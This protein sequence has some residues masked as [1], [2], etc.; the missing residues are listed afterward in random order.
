M[1]QAEK[2]QER[3]NRILS[4][5]NGTWGVVVRESG[6]GV[7]FEHLAD[8]PFIAESVIKV[9]IMAAV[10][11]ACAQG[12][13]SLE[14]RIALRRED[15]VGGSG[16]LSALS[17]GLRL[18]VRELVT[19][20]IILSDNTATN[21]LIDLVGKQQIELTM[22]ELG[23]ERS[24]YSRKLMIYPA[25]VAENNMIT[26]RDVARM[27]NRFAEGSWLSPGACEEMIGI[28]KKQQYRDGLP[29]LLPRVPSPGGKEEKA[30]DW[31]MGSK[32]GWDTG[33]R[34]DAGILYTQERCFVIVALSQDVE[35]QEALQTLGRLGKEVYEYAKASRQ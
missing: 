10:Y 21:M 8:L 13:M 28:L 6:R 12:R 35:D 11:A 17:P 19:L 29:S 25:D 4:G 31:E 15:Q 20:M 16:V 18:T 23:M 3:M 9:P 30:A 2:L 22:R 34:H 32:S 33:R 27:L 26:A 1:E 14:E 5:A 24:K 7:C